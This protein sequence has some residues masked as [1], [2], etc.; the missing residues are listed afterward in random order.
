MSTL[1]DLP[2]SALEAELKRREDA[3]KPARPQAKTLADVDWK[4]V[5]ASVCSYADAVETE[6]SEYASSKCKQ[7][8]F[9]AAME[10]VYGYSFWPWNMSR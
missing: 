8:V 3:R 9:E 2:S 10:A 6:G 1:R 7:Y 5:H 4:K